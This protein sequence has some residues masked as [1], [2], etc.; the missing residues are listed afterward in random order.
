MVAMCLLPVVQH[1]KKQSNKKIKMKTVT[2]FPGAEHRHGNSVTSF[3]CARFNKSII[4][5]TIRKAPINRLFRSKAPK[6]QQ[7]VITDIK[8]KP[9]DFFDD[10]KQ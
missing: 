1:A 8:K 7:I 4:Y 3:E 9:V 6:T 10:A 5:V 2:T